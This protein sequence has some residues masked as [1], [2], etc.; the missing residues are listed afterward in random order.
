M[1]IAEGIKDFMKSRIWTCE[2]YKSFRTTIE[3]VLYSLGSTALSQFYKDIL[4]HIDQKDLL[5][6]EL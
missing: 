2:M 5:Y 1:P 6:K 3:E 4:V